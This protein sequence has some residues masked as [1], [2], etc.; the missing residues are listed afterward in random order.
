MELLIIPAGGSAGVDSASRMGSDAPGE[1]APERGQT[2]G[3]GGSVADELIAA[4]GP[5]ADGPWHRYAK[6]FADAWYGAYS[7][8]KIPIWEDIQIAH[9]AASGLGWDVLLERFLLNK[10]SGDSIKDLND[11]VA[12]GDTPGRLR[13][14]LENVALPLVYARFWRSRGKAERALE[15]VG[16]GHRATHNPNELSGGERQR[17]AIAR[18]LVNE[19]PL[20]MADEPTGNLDSKTGEQI[21]EL[22]HELHASGVTIVLVTHEMS[23]AAQAQRVV[24]MR[25]GKIIEDRQVDDAFR[26]ELL[27]NAGKAGLK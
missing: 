25:D 27:G 6:D 13:A 18:A 9:E 10:E 14:V 19:P 17:V 8:D 26:R 21:M 11:L 12:K 16:L 24:R 2:D 4:L 7:E 5:G 1:G 23:I 3:D 20:L 22:F 15:R